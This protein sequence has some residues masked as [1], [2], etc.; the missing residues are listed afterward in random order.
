MMDLK[1]TQRRM[2]QGIGLIVFGVDALSPSW[3]GI[4][5]FGAMSAIVLFTMFAQIYTFPERK[6]FVLRV[7]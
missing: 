3:I 6:L 1:N 2:Y 4:R 7:A 5:A